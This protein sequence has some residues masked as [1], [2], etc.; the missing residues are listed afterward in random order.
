MKHLHFKSCYKLALLFLANILFNYISIG[1]TAGDYRTAASGDWNALSTWQRYDG[2]NWQTPTAGQGTPSSANSLI[3]IRNAHSVTVTANVTIDQ[4]TIA[5]GGQVTVNS[6]VTLTIN[7]GAGLYDLTINGTLV[8]SGAIVRGSS[9]IRTGIGAV[10]EHA[11]DG[12][13]VPLISWSSNSTCLITGRVSNNI[14]GLNQ[15]FGNLIWNCAGQTNFQNLPNMMFIAG[16]LE[17]IN[18]GTSELR[19]TQNFLTIQGNF[20]QSG[21]QFRVAN[22]NNTRIITINGDFTVSGGIFNLA[23]GA[24]G[25]TGEGSIDIKGD[26]TFSGGSIE[27]NSGSTNEIFLSGVGAM[28]TYSRTG[29]T[30]VNSVHFTVTAGAD[31]DFGTSI[32]DGTTGN[33]T[34]EAGAKITTANPGGFGL[35]GTIQIAGPGSAFFSSDAEYEFQGSNTGVFATTPTANTV[36]S[37]VVNSPG[38]LTLDMPLAVKTTCLF[39]AGVLNTTTTNLLTFNNDATEVGA[40]AGTYVNGPVS[41]AGDDDFTF[42]IGKSG[43]GYAP[44]GI[45][46]LTSNTTFLAEYFSATPVDTI[47]REAGITHVSAIEYWSLDRTSGA[48]GAIVT[49]SWRGSSN[50]TDPSSLLL[51]RYDSGASQWVNHPASIDAMASTLT[52]NSPVTS[53]SFFTLGSS[54]PRPTNPLPVELLYFTAAPKQDKVLLAWSTATESDNAYFEIEKTKN[55]RDFEQVL[56]VNGAGYSSSVL[57]YEAED[58]RPFQGVSYYRLKQVDFNGDY[59][60]SDLVQVALSDEAGFTWNVFPNPVEN[61][62]VNVTISAPGDAEVELQLVDAMGKTHFRSM[63]AGS[64]LILPGDLASGQYFL[65]AISQGKVLGLKSIIIK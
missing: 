61:H 27:E 12:G 3:T 56:K 10:Y 6:G 48:S 62:M 36:S 15:T 39:I 55:G 26:F 28:Q 38:G 2:S 57:T 63:L 53:F 13:I 9:T 21:G 45:S 50:V 20:I 41:K 59:S 44:I 47:D 18:T 19:L 34:V 46:G 65:S 4:T 43:I 52:T 7:N 14:S 64:Q 23:Q 11:T 32:I 5:A 29:G 58:T 17:I 16:N 54:Q 60:Y 37:L 40:S 30:Y 33:F 8:N 35:S 51:T 42:P 24:A 22:A 25:A 31:V 49:L 1:Q